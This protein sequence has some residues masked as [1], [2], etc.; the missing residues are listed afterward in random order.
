MKA[1]QTILQRLTAFGA[2][3]VVSCFVIVSTAG[4][5]VINWGIHDNVNIAGGYNIWSGSSSSEVLSRSNFSAS[6]GS[7][8]AA[9][10]N[11][12]AT[13]G[14]T[15]WGIHDNVNIAGGYNIWSGSSFSEVLSR[16]NFSASAGSAGATAWNG[17]ATDGTTYWGIHDNVNIAGGYNIWSGSSFSEVLS[18]TNFSASAGSAG[19]TAWV[20][21]AAASEPIPEPG[22]FMLLGMGLLGLVGFIHFRRPLRQVTCGS[23]GATA[24][25]GSCTVG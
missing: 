12:F 24:A 15:Y 25:S 18:R 21:F 6:A 10:W 4:A 20:G 16:S 22:T 17:F 8:G 11:G 14:T 1:R 23:S 3:M 7:A 9:A 5:T 13:D 19:A 2:V